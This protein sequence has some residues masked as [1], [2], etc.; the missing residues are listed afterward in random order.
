MRATIH[1]KKPITD[2]KLDVD[3]NSLEANGYE[4]VVHCVDCRYAETI[5]FHGEVGL[6]CNNNEGLFR[7][8]PTD[9]YCYCGAKMENED[10]KL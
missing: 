9:G 7:D 6:T 1:L 8:V 10:G 3:E 2:F 5:V 4:R